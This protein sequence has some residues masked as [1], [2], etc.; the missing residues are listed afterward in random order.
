MLRL[1]ADEDF[2]FDIVRGLLRRRPQLDIVRVHDV[3]LSRT[4]DRE[5]LAWA[6]K[7]QRIML[8]HDT[9]TMSRYAFCAEHHIACPRALHAATLVACLAGGLDFDSTKEIPAARARS[10]TWRS[11]SLNAF[12]SESKALS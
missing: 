6:A 1:L 11:W 7:E 5:I 9:N 8:T 12:T 10:P 4:H 3:E 2:N